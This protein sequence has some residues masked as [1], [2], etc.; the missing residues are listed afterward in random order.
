MYKQVGVVDVLYT[1][2]EVADT[3]G[4]VVGRNRLRTDGDNV[5]YTAVCQRPRG[6]GSVDPGEAGGREDSIREELSGR[7]MRLTTY[8]PK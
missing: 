2:A 5:S 3:R 6:D 4:R 7:A 8:V 1:D